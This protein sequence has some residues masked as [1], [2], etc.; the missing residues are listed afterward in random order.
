MDWEEWSSHSSQSAA[1]V[2]RQQAARAGSQG[3]KV[4][5][6]THQSPAA[7]AQDYR[8][9]MLLSALMLIAALIIAYLR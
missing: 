2:D 4:L 9:H 3:P 6:A 5:A 8:I 1:R 7:P